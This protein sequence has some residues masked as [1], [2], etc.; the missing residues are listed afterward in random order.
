MKW[1]RRPQEKEGTYLFSGMFLVTRN[2]SQKLSSLEIVAI[3][4]D[5]QAFVSAHNGAD[6]LQIY[7]SPNGEKLYFIDQLS[8]EMIE[9]GQF[10]EEDNYCT[11]LFSWEY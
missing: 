10:A 7:D 8:R 9:T 5:M 11:L 4:L 3:Y 6:Y 1:K 2:V